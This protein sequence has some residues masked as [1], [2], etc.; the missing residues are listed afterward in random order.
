MAIETADAAAVVLSA[1][2]APRQF[3][4]LFVCIPFTF[5]FDENSIGSGAAS[6]GD[7][8]VTGAALGDFVLIAPR[9]DVI[10]IALSGF[11]QAADTVTILAQELG[12]GANTTL[13][14]NA[15]YNGL[16]LQPRAAWAVVQ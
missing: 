7:I 5:T 14:A 4:D 15:T 8:T 2:E 1:R 10:D 11:V 3:Q 6:A 13:N 12:L 16:V 9:F